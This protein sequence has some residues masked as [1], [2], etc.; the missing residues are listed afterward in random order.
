MDHY[1][2]LVETEDSLPLLMCIDGKFTIDHDGGGFPGTQAVL[3][4]PNDEIVLDHVDIYGS[5]EVKKIVVKQSN[6]HYPAAVKGRPDLPGAG[7]E[8]ITYGYN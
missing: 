4:A 1:T 6:I 7:L 2:F 8:T 5:V 3:Y